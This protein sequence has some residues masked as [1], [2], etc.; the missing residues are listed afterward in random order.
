MLK[1][2]YVQSMCTTSVAMQIYDLILRLVPVFII[3]DIILPLCETCENVSLILRYFDIA[4]WSDIVSDDMRKPYCF[5]LV[6]LNGSALQ[7]T[8]TRDV[9]TQVSTIQD[10]IIHAN[11]SLPVCEYL[12]ISIISSVLNFEQFQILLNVVSFERLLV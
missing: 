2:L 4:S 6:S 7:F 1:S 9:F 10:I 5:V 3:P 8:N 12:I 11:I